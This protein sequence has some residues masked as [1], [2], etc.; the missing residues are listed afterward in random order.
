MTTTT[1][2]LA[3]RIRGETY[4]YVIQMKPVTK[5]NSMQIAYDRGSGKPF[6]IQSSQYRVYEEAAWVFLRPKPPKP[7]DYPVTVKCTFY[8]QKR[9]KVDTANLMAAAHD[10]LVKHG[11]LADDNRDIIASVDGTRTFW[12]KENPRTEILITPYN[13]DYET[14]RKE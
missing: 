1:K 7:I 5:K 6:L 8:V 2:E 12:D 13:E 9:N 14:W 10:I 3:D 11:I 4:K